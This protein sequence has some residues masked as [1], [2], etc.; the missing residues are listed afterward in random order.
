MNILFAALLCLT[1]LSL[2]DPE[3]AHIDVR[4]K[5][6]AEVSSADAAALAA[7]F[8]AA[9]KVAATAEEKGAA[10]E[11]L[12][13]GRHE[14]ISKELKKVLG[15]RDRAVDL[16]VVVLLGT[17]RDD[18]ARDALLAIARP[19]RKF[20]PVRGAEAVQSLGYTGYG[21]EF[22]T[23]QDLF[24]KHGS[25]GIR[26]AIVQAVGRQKDKRAVSML[27][28]VLDQP[29]PANPND[30]ANPPASWWEDKFEEWAFFK[31][32]VMVALKAITGKQFYNSETA[33]EWVEKEG[34]ALGI[35]LAKTP[36]PWT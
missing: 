28:S 19:G 26:K 17:Q 11:R 35:T 13:T 8:K 6:L 24:Y 14:V 27:I 25:K 33:I 2:E 15:D 30:P 16:K 20:D 12:V 5:E 31:D 23:F 22:K 32:D 1:T 18:T 21:D 34:R 4:E 36:A 9:W 29:R 7:V 3:A 10:L